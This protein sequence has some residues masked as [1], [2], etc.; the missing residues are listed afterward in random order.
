MVRLAPKRIIALAA[1][2]LLGTACG[3]GTRPGPAAAP[4][5]ISTDAVVDGPLTMVQ[6]TL[7][8]AIASVDTALAEIDAAQADVEDGD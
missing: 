4:E 7:D 1:L 5:P 6:A 3:A 2:V 8:Q